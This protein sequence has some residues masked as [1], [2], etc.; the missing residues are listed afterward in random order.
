[1]NEGRVAEDLKAYLI[2]KLEPEETV[3]LGYTLTQEEKAKE[4][5]ELLSNHYVEIGTCE[6]YTYVLVTVDAEVMKENED[7]SGLEEESAKE[8]L[9]LLENT[10]LVLANTKLIGGVKL[11]EA[12]ELAP[13]GN[14]IHFEAMDVDGNL[15]TSEDLF[16]GHSLT[17]VNLWATWCG[18]CR[19]EIPELE[20]IAK[21][22]AK[23]GCQIIGIVTDAD[24]EE[25]TLKA[26]DI[27]EEKGVTYLN[28]VPF[29]GSSD[30]FPQYIWPTSYFV[31][32]KAP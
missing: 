24:T 5:E 27:L 4:E 25:I 21:E 10:D 17:M 13:E 7:F 32:E 3:K 30:L 20:E 28:L 1:M 12:V 15:V 11:H 19:K 23:Q 22:V 6:D 2:A 31:D 9:S 18:P 29:E 14:A 8:Y 16:A 26:K